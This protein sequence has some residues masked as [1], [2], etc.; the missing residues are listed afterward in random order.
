MPPCHLGDATYNNILLRNEGD[1]P[2]Y[3]Y[4]TGGKE[5]VIKVKPGTGCISPNG[6]QLVAVEYR[7]YEVGPLV[8]TLTCVLNNSM[9]DSKYISI[10]GSC[11]LPQLELENENRL[12]FKPTC[13]GIVS[14]R[15]FKI[16]NVRYITL[17]IIISLSVYAHFYFFI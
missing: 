15:N 5:N 12:Y 6:S 3:F 4:F 10:H 13:L 9:S 1:T 16:K 14:K 17:T 2:S 11:Y 7:P 8:T